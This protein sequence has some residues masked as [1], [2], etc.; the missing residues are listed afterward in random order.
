VSQAVKV[1]EFGPG[2]RRI[3]RERIA[4]CRLVDARDHLVDAAP[5][6]SA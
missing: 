3:L 1:F 6:F 5:R 4:A 2:H